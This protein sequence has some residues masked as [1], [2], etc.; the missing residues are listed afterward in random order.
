MGAKLVFGLIFFIFVVALLT[1]YWFVPLSETQFIVTQSGSN[2]TI[3]D[4][5]SLELQ[6]YENMRFPSNRISYGIDKCTLKKTDDMLRAF[7]ILEDKTILEFY[8]SSNPEISIV[9][10]SRTKI[11]GGLFIA[12]E[13]GPTNITESGDFHLISHGQILLIKESDCPNP[14]IATHELMH[15]LGFDHIPNPKDIMYNISRCDQKIN[16]ESINLINEIYSIPSAPDLAFHDFSAI[17]HGKYLDVNM[18]VKNEGFVSSPKSVIEV[19]ADNKLVK[20]IDL[21]SLDAGHGRIISLT[22]VWVK[23][24]SVDQIELVIVSSAEE[25]SNENNRVV[26]HISG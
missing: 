20:K 26:L 9:C 19:Y 16:N 22:N 1:L 21:I 23:Q 11:D 12:G 4:L 5:G 10:D 17:M 15:V 24:I 13:G 18:T 2:F 25:L 6:F 14:N 8:P 7:D 3:G